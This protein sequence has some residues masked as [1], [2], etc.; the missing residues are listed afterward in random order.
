MA[1]IAKET[2]QNFALH[3]QLTASEC[4]NASAVA[5]RYLA[6]H[7][8][9]VPT[10]GAYASVADDFRVVEL[11]THNP[12]IK[13]YSQNGNINIATY[14]YLMSS[15]PNDTKKPR[16]LEAFSQFSDEFFPRVEGEEKWKHISRPN[17]WKEKAT[18][19]ALNFKNASNL[20]GLIEAIHGKEVAP[21]MHQR[22]R[23]YNV[24]QLKSE[25]L[26]NDIN[27]I[28]KQVTVP[29]QDMVLLSS[30][31]M[32]TPLPKEDDLPRGPPEVAPLKNVLITKTSPPTKKLEE[33][34]P[35]MEAYRKRAGINATV[36]TT[37][38]AKQM[39]YAAL[40]TPVENVPPTIMGT[41]Q[42]SLTPLA[43]EEEIATA[44][45][46]IEAF[47][48]VSIDANASAY[49]VALAAVCKR[50]EWDTRKLLV[51]A[52]YPSDVMDTRA[53]ARLVKTCPQGVAKDAVVIQAIEQL[54]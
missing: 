20:Y 12:P 41:F 3:I 43:G 25:D 48:H 21:V 6:I 11:R 26:L 18:F 23:A 10:I 39:L 33:L 16:R 9:V 31:Q 2:L 32:G 14:I 34:R 15:I 17:Q 27:V 29:A 13:V 38:I 46:A 4:E 54:K 51:H 30:S 28:I 49:L 36:S 47:E 19:L 52:M 40:G 24:K 45:D 5:H 50:Y 44:L 37:R 53:H 8:N 35:R 42:K 1:D 7:V 22:V